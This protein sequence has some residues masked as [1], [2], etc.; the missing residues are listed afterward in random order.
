MN[1]PFLKNLFG[2]MP[3]QQFLAEYWQKKPLLVR[4]ALPGFTGLLSRDELID[5]ACSDEAESR[6]VSQA[7]GRW[8]IEHGPFKRERLRRAKKPWTTLIQGL[9]LLLPEADRLMREFSFI[10]YARLDDLMVSYANDGGG[11]GPHFDNYDV[12][13]LQGIGKRRWRIGNQRDQELIEGLPL[14]ILK[15]FRPKHDWVLESGDL[16]Y[17]PPEWAHDGI[18]IGE[19]MT[20]SVGFRTAPAQELAEQFL[21]F[22]AERIELPGRYS[23]PDLPLQRHPAEIGPAMVEQVGRLLA[24]IR[25]NDKLVKEFLG[26][27]LSEPKAQVFFER[28]ARPLSAPRFAAAAGKRGLR[29]DAR[30]QML[31]SDRLFFI[32]GEAAA[33]P[34]VDR[35]SFRRLADDRRLDDLAGISADGQ[36]L[37]HDWYRCGFLAPA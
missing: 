15:D 1:T 24:G 20:Y 31:F 2:G 17:L 35:A 27:T 36:T 7:G 10:P 11:V 6:F 33:V 29:L 13:L 5:L 30:T 8:T 25:W 21:M 28:P 26:H 19:C 32:N 12:F 34:A 23:D 22:L 37:L 4:N 16:L 18:A 14:R 9:N 3:V